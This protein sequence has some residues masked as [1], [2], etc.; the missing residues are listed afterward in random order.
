MEHPQFSQKESAS[1]VVILA[2]ILHVGF[3][4]GGHRLVS[5]GVFPKNDIQLFSGGAIGVAE[6]HL[7]AFSCAHGVFGIGRVDEAVVAIG[8]V[9]SV[10]RL[11]AGSSKQA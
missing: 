5:H 4:H 8:V 2:G 11:I 7:R 3:Q 6:V 1:I 10:G 9:G